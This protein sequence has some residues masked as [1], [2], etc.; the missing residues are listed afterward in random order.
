MPD[1][2]VSMA[3]MRLSIAGGGTDLPEFYQGGP[4]RVIGVAIDR[5]VWVVVAADRATARA[6]A[7]GDA[8]RYQVAHDGCGSDPYL[9]AVI[10][11]LGVGDRF[12]VA[13]GSSVTPGSGLG[14]SGAFLVALLDAVARF[15]GRSISPT[16]LAE[17]AFTTERILLG[18]T[19]GKQDGWLAALGGAT[20]LRITPDG[21]VAA[22]P[23]TDV[24]DAMRALLDSSL[25]LF[26]TPGTRDAGR[27]LAATRGVGNQDR[28]RAL[29]LIEDNERA[30][31]SRDVLR[32]GAVLRRHWRE[33]VRRNPAADHPVCQRLAARANALGVLGFKLVGAGGGGHLLVAARP[34]DKPQVVANLGLA[35]LVPEKV[36]PIAAGLTRVDS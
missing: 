11:A 27:V 13:I 19:V 29:E 14:G 12:H 30:V 26:R 7:G 1:H 22:R 10:E 31:L 35:G 21:R 25:L 17:L 3:P 9:R 28:A 20:E 34:E 36:R 15:H 16:E 23:R 33:K 32:V 6:V 24:F 18:R 8:V 2:V 4:G 5:W